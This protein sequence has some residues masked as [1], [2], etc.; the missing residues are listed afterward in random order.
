MKERET[1]LE[2]S[3][4]KEE[5]T[6]PSKRTTIPNISFLFSNLQAFSLSSLFSTFKPPT[7]PME[8]RR[9]GFAVILSIVIILALVSFTFCIAAE[10]KRSKKKDLKL[11]GKLCY[12]PGSRA[13]GLGMAALICLLVAQIIANLIVCRNFCSG[14][15]RTS[16]IDKEQT[17]LIALAVVSWIS[18][19]IAVILISAA[20]SMNRMQPYGRG[21]LD[22]ECYIVKDGVFIGSGILVLVTVSSTLVLAVGTMRKSQVDQGRKVHAQVAE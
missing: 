1:P 22:G 8:K 6:T 12:L 15:K 14:E 3:F 16:N 13:F 10:F 7:H 11:D 4:T 17:F 9:C 19:G 5:G 2:E 20:T 21:W 18:V